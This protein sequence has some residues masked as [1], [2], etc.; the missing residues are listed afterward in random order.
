MDDLFLKTLDSADPSKEDPDRAFPLA[1]EIPAEEDEL[2]RLE[3][4]RLYRRRYKERQKEKDKQ[5]IQQVQETELE[6]ERLRLE[7]AA[8][9]SQSH[10]LASLCTYS[11][12][13]V[14]ALSAAASAS[15]AKAISLGGQAI[16]GVNTFRGW[17]RHQ[18]IMLPTAAELMMGSVWLPT[19]DHMR[20][21]MKVS[22]PED[23]VTN[24]A[25]FIERLAELL[26]EGKRSEE[27]K[28]H[29]ELKIDYLLSIWVSFFYLF[30]SLA[31]SPAL[32][33]EY[34][35]FIFYFSL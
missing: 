34:Q 18:W 32:P 14:E 16:E 4:S 33:K 11:N 9:I 27:A 1:N 2:S 15:A 13:M 8:L 24:H 25:K 5:L 3:R 22:K 20:F 23:F 26:E 29:V 7:Q 30:F 28:H 35:F 21:V 6:V 17:A 31:G 12:S 10:A 19:D